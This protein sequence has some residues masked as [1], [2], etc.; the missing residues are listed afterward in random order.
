MYFFVL[1]IID[2]HGHILEIYTLV[3]EIHKNVDIV[4]GIKNVFELEGVINCWEC[5]F[6]FL[7]R[8]IPLFLKEEIIVKPKGQK[9]INIESPSLDEISD[10]AIIKLLDRSTQRTVMLKIKFI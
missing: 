3:S 10:L 9:L 2:I 6:S 4:F 5:C 8:S 7:K 1:I